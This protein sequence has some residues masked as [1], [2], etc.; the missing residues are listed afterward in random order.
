[1]YTVIFA[2]GQGS[3][4]S[5]ETNK[6]PKP[7]VK[8]GKKP[9]IEHIIN[10]YQKYSFNKFIILTGYKSGE[11]LKYFSKK[12][13]YFIKTLGRKNNQIYKDFL[14]CKNKD[15]IYL[16]LLFTGLKSNKFSR[17]KKCKKMLKDEKFF[18]LTYGDGITDCNITKLKSFFIKKKKICSILAVNPEPRFGLLD[19]DGIYVK[20]FFEKKKI[21]N[22]YVNAGFMVCS[23]KIF[24]YF[25]FRNQN[26][27]FET[28]LLPHLAKKNE[29]I[30]YKYNKF[31]YS[32]DTLRDKNYLDKLIKNKNAPWL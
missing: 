17:L 21:K 8:I 27:D 19:T 16:N 11:F 25:K 31:W 5:E 15:K 1:M 23:V 13:N 20:K 18:F 26:V 14:K 10:H 30:C 12:K 2:G 32:M 4:L 24:N 3:R 6:L 28:D 29:L 7:L 9:I 22:N